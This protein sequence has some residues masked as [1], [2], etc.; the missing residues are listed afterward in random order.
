MEIIDLNSEKELDSFVCQYSN[1]GGAEFLQSWSWGES[2]QRLGQTVRRLGVRSDGRLLAV[3]TLIKKPLPAGYSY[4]YA[5][6]GPLGSPEAVVFLINRIKKENPRTIFWRLEP[7]EA[8]TNDSDRLIQL[9]RLLRKTIDL[10]PKQSLLIDLTQ[11]EDVI[12][13]AMHQKTR[14]NIRLAQKKGLTV[15]EGGAEDFPEFWR[16]M[17]L[18]GERDG[19]RL[20]DAAHYQNL[21]TGTSLVKL[22][23]V[24]YEGK[25]IAAGLFCF[26]EDKATYLHGASDNE[27]RNLMAPYLLQWEMMRRAKAAGYKYYDFF[28]IDEKKWPGVTRFKLGFGG[29]RVDYPGTFDA[30]FRPGLYRLYDFLRRIRR[31]KIYGGNK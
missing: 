1:R 21:L 27:S 12:L 19:F 3:A 23:L 15:E 28:G 18:T 25:N 11:P 13:A 10:Q 14:Y 2:A 30:V 7:E 24:R 22:Y 6:R 9:S 29:C 31:K 26:W 16:L 5:P 20:H 8:V 4:L 17:S